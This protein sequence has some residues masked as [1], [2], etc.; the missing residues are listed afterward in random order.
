MRAAGGGVT[1]FYEVFLVDFL[2]T[3]GHAP[4]PGTGKERDRELRAERFPE[5]NRYVP[6]QETHTVLGGVDF[7]V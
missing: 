1:L 3:F 4:F 2:T 7:A 6:W 5:L